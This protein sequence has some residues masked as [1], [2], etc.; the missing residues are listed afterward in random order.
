MHPLQMGKRS[1]QGCGDGTNHWSETTIDT[2]MYA[3]PPC[4]TLYTVK[5]MRPPFAAEVTFSVIIHSDLTWTLI[6][7][8]LPVTPQQLPVAPTRI[9]E[10]LSLLATLDSV[11]FC[12]VFETDRGK[13]PPYGQDR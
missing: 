1:A 6:L 12:R 2:S 5:C 9:P 11:K 7:G 3:D 10:V 8:S 13:R 4:M